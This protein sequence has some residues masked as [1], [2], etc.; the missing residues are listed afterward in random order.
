MKKVEKFSFE[1]IEKGYKKA[2][3]TIGGKKKK[4][5]IYAIVI[6]LVYFAL[7]GFIANVIWITNLIS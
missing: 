4:R 2:E 6:G 7:T 5:I 1:E 3:K